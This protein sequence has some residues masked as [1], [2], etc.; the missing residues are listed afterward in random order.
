[1]HPA[2][3]ITTTSKLIRT[4]LDQHIADW[5]SCTRCPLHT[6][7]RWVVL[8]RGTLPCDVLFVGEAPGNSENDI[9]KPFIGQAGKILDSLISASVYRLHRTYKI[10]W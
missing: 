10:D 3:A 7:R 2:H 4:K 1:M 5:E 9:G 6:T 8:G